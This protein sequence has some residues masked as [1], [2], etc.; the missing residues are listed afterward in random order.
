MTEPTAGGELL[1]RC[2]KCGRTFHIDALDG[3]PT[4]NAILKRV[5]QA[6][7]QLG[8][9]RY[10]ADHGFE[11][12]RLGCVGCYGPGFVKQGDE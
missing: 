6:Q 10:A 3:K 1:D 7:G 8:M 12:D 2:D 4:E 5:R 11:F 9:L